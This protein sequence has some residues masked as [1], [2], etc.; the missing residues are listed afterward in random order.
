MV[1]KSIIRIWKEADIKAIAE[2]LLIAGST[3]GDCG[4]CKEV[5]ISLDAKECPKCGNLFKYM[6]TR[7]SNSI[8]EAKRLR[9][10]R[11]NLII[12]DFRDFKEMQARSK[13][14]GILGE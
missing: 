11:P 8:R 3:T 2:H 6:G 9:L 12:I 5:G 13:A 1:S 7:I 10:K 14:R 4:N